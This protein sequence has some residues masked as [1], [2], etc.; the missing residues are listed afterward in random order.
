[1]VVDGH[2]YGGLG[3]THILPKGLDHILFV[4]GLFLLGTRWRP[5]LLQ[6]TLF[7]VATR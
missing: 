1:M 4:V 7:T 2:R 5:L 3:F 6:I